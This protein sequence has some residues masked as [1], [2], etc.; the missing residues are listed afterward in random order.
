MISSGVIASRVM[1]MLKLA[2][3]ALFFV[4][5]SLTSTII[6]WC[7]NAA[8]QLGCDLFWWQ[9]KTRRKCTG[10]RA[11]EGHKSIYDTSMAQ[12]L[13]ICGD[14]GMMIQIGFDQCF[15]WLQAA[16]SR[17]PSLGSRSLKE[18]KINKRLQASS[19]S[20]RSST[21]VD[22]MLGKVYFSLTL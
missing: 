16:R 9:P 19:L 6:R 21:T 10:L 20:D 18:D 2:K 1:P 4:T 7:D 14:W 12:M 22:S 15:G 13:N 3:P 8:L 5:T 11:L 17:R